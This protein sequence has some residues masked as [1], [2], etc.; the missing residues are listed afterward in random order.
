MLPCQYITTYNEPRSRNTFRLCVSLSVIPYFQLSFD[1]FIPAQCPI[2]IIHNKTLCVCISMS[3]RSGYAH[4]VLTVRGARKYLRYCTRDGFHLLLQIVTGKTFS[5]F[6]RHP[7]ATHWRLRARAL[8]PGRAC[9]HNN[10]SSVR[11]HEGFAEFGIGVGSNNTTD[12]HEEAG[13]VSRVATPK[14]PPTNPKVAPEA[15]MYWPRVLKMPCDPA[16]YLKMLT[17]PN[18]CQPMFLCRGSARAYH[19]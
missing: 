2:P 4:R 15:P 18:S 19:R 3:L 8:L 7:N 5:S 1:W 11:A 12:G 6:Q 9:H 14:G 17:V 16:P 10:R 13:A